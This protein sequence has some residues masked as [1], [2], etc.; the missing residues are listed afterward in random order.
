MQGEIGGTVGKPKMKG[1]TCPLKAVRG[2]ADAIRNRIRHS[3][4]YR[5]STLY[6]LTGI[7]EIGDDRST[8]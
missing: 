6:F 3:V 1:F 5:S 8:K 2:K 7:N 4:K